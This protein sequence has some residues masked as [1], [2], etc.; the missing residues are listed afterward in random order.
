M[1][2]LIANG[3]RKAVSGI[4]E[5]LYQ[6]T[7]ATEHEPFEEA[8]IRLSLRLTWIFFVSGLVYA[9]SF[10]SPHYYFV[11]GFAMGINLSLLLIP[12]ALRFGLFRL[13]QILYFGIILFFIV[14]NLWGSGNTTS[15]PVVLWMVLTVQLTN[16]ILTSG[17]SFVIACLVIVIYI[18]KVI[19][20]E[21]NFV[22]PNV[23][24]REIIQTPRIIDYAAP[25]FYNLS[26]TY[27]S[28]QFNKW[29][30]LQLRSS[31]EKV[32]T[33]NKA[34]ARTEWRNNMIVENSLG[35]ISIHDEKGILKF[36][37]NATSRALGFESSDLLGK[38]VSH[39]LHPD[40]RDRFDSYLETVLKTSS[41]EGIMRVVTSSGTSLFW[42]YR[43]LSIVY[44]NNR[45][46]LTFAHDVTELEKTRQQ[47]QKARADAEESDRLK[48]LFLANISHE[49]RTPMNAIIGFSELLES[50][51]LTAARRTIFTRHIRE[52]SLNLL[53][54]LNNLIDFSR[55]EA[56]HVALHQMDGNIDEL[57]N[58]VVVA[59]GAETIYITQKNVEIRKENRL[60]AEMQRAR[61]DYF[62]LNQVLVNLMSN[63]IKF[64]EA[65]YVLLECT[66]QSPGIIRFSIT[67]TGEGIQPEKLETIFKPFRQAN[68]SIQRKYGGSGL[69][70]AICKG[71]VESWDGQ[72]WAESLPGRG[73]TFHFTVP[74]SAALGDKVS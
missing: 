4:E 13:R 24:P 47:L 14:V 30:R 45:S 40:V 61:L 23:L 58:K 6:K 25:M 2:N 26:L 60:K 15:I 70:L 11:L 32:K 8:K 74:W 63:A 12:V 28:Y 42:Y 54:M 35:V 9:T 5:W 17:S 7:A 16:A 66:E 3:Y 62:K 10:I 49:F 41:A 64:T 73:S 72:I 1:H 44:D 59:I 20:V 51:N 34:I 39:V 27:N 46:V 50:P 68:D 52:R 22:F 21:N 19:A 55:L 53:G 71:L 31:D 67:D 38:S 69:G 57:M 33:L 18:I 48:S 29:A 37:N 43:A 56:G 36:I 65:G